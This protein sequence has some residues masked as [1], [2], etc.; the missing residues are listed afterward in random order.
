MTVKA[1]PGDN[2]AVHGALA[3][4]IPGTVLV[5]DWR[6]S[7]QS[8]GAGVSA[9]LPAVAN[10]LA[11]IA[12]DGGWWDVAEIEVLGFPVIASGNAPFSPPDNALGEMNVPVAWDGVIVEPGDLIVGDVDGMV[13]V[14]RRYVDRVR[15]AVVREGHDR[16]SDDPDRQAIAEIVDRY[17]AEV[18]LRRS[19]PKIEGNDGG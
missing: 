4:T 7:D 5:I 6:A 14:P 17:W 12:V 13:V 9:L 10:G 1:P 16:G 3:R 19:N 8:C 18:E 2:W 15:R 11:G